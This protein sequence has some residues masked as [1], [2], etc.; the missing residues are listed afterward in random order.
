[1][2]LGTSGSPT[3]W[4]DGTV[5]ISPGGS[6]TP[7]TGTV[8]LWPWI[9][10]A[11]LVSDLEGLV[12]YAGSRGFGGG[13]WPANTLYAANEL[14]T[15]EALSIDQ[16]RII[17]SCDLR[18]LSGTPSP[19]KL[20]LCYET[21][22]T[23]G[24]STGAVASLTEAQWSNATIA[25][26]VGGAAQ[27]ATFWDNTTYPTKS[28]APTWVGKKVIAPIIR[29]ANAVDQLVAWV[30]ASPG[31]WQQIIAVSDSYDDCIT[32]I[33][34]ADVSMNV[35]QRFSSASPTTLQITT[36]AA[37][38]IYG[39]LVNSAYL[40]SAVI[41]SCKANDIKVY[42]Y[43]ADTPALVASYTAMVVDGI[44]A[45]TPIAAFTPTTPPPPVTPTSTVW[46]WSATSTSDMNS[47]IAG[48]LSKP[49]I[50]RAYCNADI[51]GN[52]SVNW[53][54]DLF[55]TGKPALWLSCKPSLSRMNDPAKLALDT[56]NY[57]KAN[58]VKGQYI[59]YTFWHE[60]EGTDDVGGGAIAAKQARWHA[61]HD[62][63]YDEFVAARAEGWHFYVA[64][65]ICDWVCNQSSGSS[66][67]TLDTW[68]PTSWQKYDVQGYDVYPQGKN[69]S[70]SNDICRVACSADNVVLP[71]ADASRY[72]CYQFINKISAHAKKCGKP[73]GSGETGIIRQDLASADVLYNCT[74]Q[75]KGQRH[76][77]I[78][79]H[80]N[81][82]VNP[83][84]IW[85]WYDDGGCTLHGND[86]G[87]YSLAVWN[88]TIAASAVL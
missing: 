87:G 61:I 8:K 21:V 88:A 3:G 24:A 70:G 39:L 31:T 37:N 22:A 28:I 69:G 27:P 26:P 23:T 20:V 17:G 79:N 1:M 35:M 60:P 82:L 75:Q 18:I 5:T 34:N 25:S 78:V 86:P 13:E 41:N 73:W 30:N 2:W 38:S 58:T 64:P 48:G 74:L 53:N 47:A 63:L 6:G 32:M 4:G 71:Y 85:T 59:F 81:S 16:P 15:N 12:V 56:V 11:D 66:K 68:Y 54:E 43:N 40:S 83:P 52:G 65:I 10:G 67:G 77:D 55:G 42:V 57:L 49:K 33:T 7:L 19:E 9:G 80:V 44:Y 14:F 36:A 29:D 50:I 84:W 46:G 62:A 76:Q 51:N 45:T 72:D